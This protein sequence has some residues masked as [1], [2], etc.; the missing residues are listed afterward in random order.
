VRGGISIG[1]VSALEYYP[2]SCGIEQGV[3]GHES[4]K[5]KG[6]ERGSVVMHRL[7]WKCF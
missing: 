2:A 7:Q 4:R 5:G 1:G 3:L 6:G